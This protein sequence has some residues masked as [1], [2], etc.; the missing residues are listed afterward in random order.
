MKVYCDI[1]GNRATI[2]KVKLL[3]CKGAKTKKDAYVLK[4]YAVYDNN[5]NYFVSV[6]ETEEAAK[7]KLK[8]FSCGT[9]E[10]V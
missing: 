7:D 6:Y 2:E 9:F 1:F 8:E 10:E 3:P 4:C 5:F